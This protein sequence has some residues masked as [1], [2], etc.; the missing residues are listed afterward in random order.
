MTLAFW[1]SYWWWTLAVF[2][3]DVF[4]SEMVSLVEA[5]RTGQTHIQDWTLSDTIRR[6]SAAHRWLGPLIVGATAFLTFHFVG[7][8]NP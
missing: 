7:Q 6:W 4:G 8:A 3:A 2:A 5:H 1:T